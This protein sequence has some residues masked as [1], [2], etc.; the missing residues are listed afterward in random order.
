MS[1]ESG[2]GGSAYGTDGEGG[3]RPEERPDET[4]RQGGASSD[5]SEARAGDPLQG[6]TGGATAGTAG[7]DV[8]AGIGTGAG[9]AGVATG[10]DDDTGGL[11]LGD[12]TGREAEAG[13]GD[14]A[15]DRLG[16]GEGET[17]AGLTGAGS[18]TGDAD[19][20]RS[21]GGGGG[22]GLGGVD[23]GSPGGMGGV[24]ARGGTGLGRP[25]GGVSPLGSDSEAED[26]R[27]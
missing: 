22:N 19:G 6:G 8:L 4:A 2:S 21:E 5:E 13:S 11:T 3:V 12:P 16:G 10:P 26:D 7:R 1:D 20:M 25:R 15:A 24:R 18:A 14:A 23:A 17:G 27:G 9:A